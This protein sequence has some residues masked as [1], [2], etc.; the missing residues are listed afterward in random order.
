MSRHDLDHGNIDFVDSEDDNNIHLSQVIDDADRY[1]SSNP[2]R[3]AYQTNNFFLPQ[4]QQMIESKK[5]INLRPEYQRRLSWSKK[6]KSSLIESLLLNIPISPIFLFESEAARYEVLDGQQ[7]MNA[8]Q[9]FLGNDHSLTDLEIFKPL[10]GKRY[11]DC[12]PRVQRTLER[13]SI[14]AIVFLLENDTVSSMNAKIVDGSPRLTNLDI[15]RLVFNRINTGGLNLNPQEIRSAMNPGLFNDAIIELTRWRP[16]TD[17]F[18]IPSYKDNDANSAYTDP[19]RQGNSLFK[20]MKDC[21]IVLRFFALREEENIRGSMREMLD[22]AMEKPRSSDEVHRATVEYKSIFSRLFELFDKRPF[23]LRMRGRDAKKIS[24]P[25]YDGLMVAMGRLLSKNPERKF[26]KKTIIGR[27]S[28]ATEKPDAYDII[29]GRANTA[30][31]VR[32]RIEM[33][34][35][36]LDG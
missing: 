19:K 24:V 29:V 18:D 3:I 8:I 10:N 30:D 35:T 15:R 4:I 12:S 28:A 27:L 7:R 20:T 31:A 9:E 33:M 21:E 6:K 5:T 14:S 34:M 25:L 22:R 17:A 16:F 1:L 36:V 26:G 23:R 13:A 2:F 11:S 32:K